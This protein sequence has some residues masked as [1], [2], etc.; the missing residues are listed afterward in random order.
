M[1]SPSNRCPDKRG[2][3][4]SPQNLFHFKT[5]RGCKGAAKAGAF[6]RCGGGSEKKRLLASIPPAM[7]PAAE[8]MMGNRE[9]VGTREAIGMLSRDH[10]P[11]LVAIEPAR[12]LQFRAIDHDVL[13]QRARGDRKSVV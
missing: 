13:V 12:V 7:H 10:Q 1:A 4:A 5:L 8:Q 11:R 6:Q 3:A 2:D 9:G